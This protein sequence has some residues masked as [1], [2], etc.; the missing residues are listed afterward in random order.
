MSCYFKSLS[1]KV[2]HLLDSIML[3]SQIIDTII[4]L[5]RKCRHFDEILIIGCTGSCHFDEIFIKMKTFPFQ[6]STGKFERNNPPFTI[7]NILKGEFNWNM[8]EITLPCYVMN[9]C[10]LSRLNFKQHGYLKDELIGYTHANFHHTTTFGC[11]NIAFQIWRLPCN[12][13]RSEWPK[14]FLGGVCVTRPQW[15]KAVW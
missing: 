15:V 14:T 4:S 10:I 12:P 13:H 6:W 9:I 7:E 11:R 8:Y 2:S 5:K 1:D 3:L